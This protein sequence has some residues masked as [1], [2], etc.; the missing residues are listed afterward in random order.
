MSKKP[1]K[2]ATRPRARQSSTDRSAASYPV[3]Q[4]ELDRQQTRIRK[5]AAA[6]TQALKTPGQVR[7]EF[8]ASQATIAAQPLALPAARISLKKAQIVREINRRATAQTVNVGF[9]LIRPGARQV[10]LC[11]EFNGWSPEAGPMT[12]HEDGHWEAI[13]ALAPGRYEYKFLVDGE[14][15]TDPVV[16]ETVPNGY[17]SVNSVIEIKLESLRTRP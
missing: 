1:A 8:P 15:L 3:E 6:G 5:A 2:T 16:Q 17:G 13:V 10:A 7:V 12:R 11:G 9:A 14:W 4:A